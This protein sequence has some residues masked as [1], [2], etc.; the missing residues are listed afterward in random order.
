MENSHGLL[1]KQ[2]NMNSREQ[3]VMNS[4]LKLRTCLQLMPTHAIQFRCSLKFYFHQFVCSYAM[5]VLHNQSAVSGEHSCAANFLKLRNETRKN[6]ENFVHSLLPMSDDV[7]RKIKAYVFGIKACDFEDWSED[8]EEIREEMVK[9]GRASS[10]LM[11]G[12]AS[13]MKVLKKNEEDADISFQEMDL[14]KK[15]YED[16]TN[17][18]LTAA[19]HHLSRKKTYEQIGLIF[20]LPTLGLITRWSQARAEQEQRKIEES[21]LKASASKRNLEILIEAANLTKK[22][23]IPSIKIFLAGHKACNAFIEAT[24]EQLSKLSNKEEGDK[25]VALRSYFQK[26]KKHANELDNDCQRVITSSSH[27]RTDLKSISSEPGDGNHVDE[28]LVE[29]LE[30][31]QTK[32]TGGGSLLKALRDGWQYCLCGFSSIVFSVLSNRTQ[33]MDPIVPPDTLH[34]YGSGGVD[35]IKDEQ[36]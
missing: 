7:V 13:M 10:L 14:L 34:K 29:Q 15:V 19:S 36:K 8:L 23:L 12:H 11:E 5:R 17:L 4:L 25:T 22:S 24:T 30:K 27:F 9:A 32:E 21:L 2:E 26:M 18:L 16:E 1:M 33:S 28:W 20:W 35:G 6:A 31:L 3:E